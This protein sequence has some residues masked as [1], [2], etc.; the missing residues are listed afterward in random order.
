MAFGRVAQKIHEHYGI[1]ISPGAAGTITERHARAIT[2]EIMT[3]PVR[4]TAEPLTLVAEIDGSMIPVVDTGAIEEAAGESPPADLRKTRR[5]SW[6]EAKLSL[7]RRAD[8]VEP[9]FAVTLGD[10]VSAGADVKRLADAAGMNER[11]RVHGLGDG[12]P[13]IA[14]QVERQ[15]GACGGYLVDF[16]HVCEYLA[17]AAKVCGKDYPAAWMELQ[18]DRLKTGQLS[19]VME[20][21]RP[22]QEQDSTAAQ[23][24]PVR[25]CFRYL[26][27]RSGQFKYQESLAANLPIGSGEVESAHRYVIQERLKLPGAWWKKSNAQAML[28]LRVARA[29]YCWDEYWDALVA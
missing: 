17:A 5:V 19:A 10:A 18:K 27:N 4:Q 26:Q 29:N 11:S 22:Y 16:Y 12:A 28:N 1:D 7:V 24:A 2:E 23:D 8:E 13:W 20:A 6:K 21:L 9:L 25:Q 3:P 15:F 14:E